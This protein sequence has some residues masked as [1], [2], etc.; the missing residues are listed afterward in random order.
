LLRYFVTVAEELHFGR[1][2]QRLYMA[3]PPLSTAIKLLETRLGMSLLRRG[4]RRVELTEA[5]EV[6]LDCSRDVL[7]AHAAMLDQV[8]ALRRSAS[9]SLRIA[10]PG[11][12]SGC[13]LARALR[14]WEAHADGSGQVDLV[15]VGP[16]AGLTPLRDNEADIAVV[17]GAQGADPGVASLTVAQ[18]QAVCAVAATH[19]LAGRSAVDVLE[20]ADEPLIQ[21][22][23]APDAWLDAWTP[24]AAGGNNPPGVLHARRLDE[25]F[26]LVAAGRGLLIVPDLV[27]ET[28]SRPDLT[29]VPVRGLPTAAVRFVWRG[30]AESGPLADF[31]ST[32][33]SGVS[34]GAHGGLVAGAP[35]TAQFTGS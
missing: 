32:L 22:A 3:Q 11:A 34:F 5:G 25:A 33:Q 7:R 27:Q 19:A 24:R 26:E 31:I 12:F 23:G 1:A 21:L 28:R 20:L 29:Y 14:S 17:L 2:A 10:Y 16:F 8:A 18:A 6:L 9:G 30:D 4:S 35:N 15:D 13:L